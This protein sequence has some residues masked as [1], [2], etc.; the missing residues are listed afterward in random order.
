MQKTET[1]PQDVLDLAEEL[2]IG[3]RIYAVLEV[4]REMFPGPVSAETGYDPEW[5]ED[6]W[7]T[8]NVEATG[9]FKE[10]IDREIEWNRRIMP[11]VSPSLDVV[12]L[13]VMPR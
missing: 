2:G 6:R 5:P 11:M 12:S 8:F 4:T 9:T 1:L 13:F 10:I 3:E 7:I